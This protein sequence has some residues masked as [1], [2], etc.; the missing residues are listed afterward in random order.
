[1]DIRTLLL[2]PWMTPTR[3]ISWERAV[4]LSFLGK[5][6]VVE[7]YELVV[8]APSLEMRMPAVV[9]QRKASAVRPKRPAFSRAHVL[10]R[11]QFTCQYCAERKEPQALNM[12]HVVP[13]AQGGKTSWENIVTS[14]YPCN[15]RKA[16]R[17]PEEARMRLLKRP[18]RPTSLPPTMPLPK[19]RDIPAEWQPYC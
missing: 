14:C 8:R 19:A 7:E 15:Q 17:T 13:R 6:E 2:T 1:M 10:L 11:D 9:R 3:V 16:G 12:D 4:V 5:V 18:V